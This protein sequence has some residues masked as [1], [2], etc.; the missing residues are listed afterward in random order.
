MKMR[1]QLEQEA[2]FMEVAMKTGFAIMKGALAIED[3]T[4]V[5]PAR[6]FRGFLL[7]SSFNNISA[8]QEM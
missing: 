7:A 5:R 2:A 3:D 6:G 4:K 8:I 1:E